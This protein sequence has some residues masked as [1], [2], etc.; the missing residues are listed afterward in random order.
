MN[1]RRPP[2]RFTTFDN[3]WIRELRADGKTHPQVAKEMGIPFWNVTR[4]ITH[5]DTMAKNPGAKIRQCI[6]PEC[7]NE[8][9]SQWA[10]HRVCGRCRKDEDSSCEPFGNFVVVMP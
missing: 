4:Q 1:K 7:K 9:V 3:A 10:G 6:R 5:L 2:H 8:F